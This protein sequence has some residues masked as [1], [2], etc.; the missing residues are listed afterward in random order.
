MRD[1]AFESTLLVRAVQARG[2]TLSWFQRYGWKANIPKA[3]KPVMT[4]QDLY[5]FR[6]NRGLKLEVVDDVQAKLDVFG[7]R[8]LTGKFSKM[9]SERIHA[10]IDPRLVC[11]LREIWPTEVG[12]IAGWLPDKKKQNF[13]SHSRSR[14][15]ADRAEN[16]SGQ[17]QTIYS[18]GP[19][20]H[21]N[22][23]TSCGVIAER[24]N[25]VETRHKVFPILGEATASSPS[26]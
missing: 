25:V 11:K 16:P 15:C 2:M 1:V 26:N 14:F 6:R 5:S 18:E 13:G 20:F 9:F 7:K 24:V 12:E 10:D 4:F 22:L 21:P 19:K 23:F 17:L 8:P 3:C